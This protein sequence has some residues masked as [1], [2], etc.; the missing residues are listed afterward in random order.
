[1]KTK[2]KKSARNIT[3]SMQTDQRANLVFLI[4]FLA[5]P[6][7]CKYFSIQ[8]WENIISF[9]KVNSDQHILVPRHLQ[10]RR[11]VLSMTN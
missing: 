8:E 2:E 5:T 7:I 10:F 11:T 3:F 9:L 6:D 1:M 4:I